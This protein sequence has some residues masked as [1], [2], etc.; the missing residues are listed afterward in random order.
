MTAQNFRLR[1]H[2]PISG[3]ATRE[4]FVGDEADLRVSL[5]FTPKWYVDRLGIDFS[6]QW[7]LDPDTRYNSLLKMKNYLHKTF[8][9][10]PYFKPI[11][12]QDV[13]QSC[14]TISGVFGIM[15]IS[16]LYGLEIDYRRDNWP[17]A[18]K[19]QRIPVDELKKLKPF[20]IENHPVF[21]TII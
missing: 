13:E 3:P 8:P 2:I 17:D 5:G 19:D 20:N 7:H 16:S 1:N 12:E 9:M 21:F 11:L 4:P 6:E 14:A 10:V 15:L 18:K